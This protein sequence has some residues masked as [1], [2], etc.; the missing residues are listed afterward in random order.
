M[1][2]QTIP[3]SRDAVTR[4]SFC[5]SD[6]AAALRGLAKTGLPA[7]PIATLSRSNA[8]TGKNTSPRTSSSAGHRELVGAGQPVGD[9][10]DGADVGGDV[11]A[12]AAVAAGQRPGQPAALVEQVDREAVDLELAQQ[13]GVVDAVA[14]E[15]GV[16]RLQLVV[17]EGVVEA[18]H[19]LQVVDGGELGRDRA[20]DL[21]GRAS[22]GCAARG[23][24]PR[25]PGARAA[26]GRSR[27]R[28]A[29]GSSRTK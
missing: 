11:L 28:R 17:G 22:R 26:G 24:P 6:P 1:P 27:R 2:W 14:A 19:A 15:P 9:G 5:R 10:G 4:G 12:G 20:A 23:T 16:P 25:A 8:S 21:L 7:S 13:R 18:L 3:R 29:S